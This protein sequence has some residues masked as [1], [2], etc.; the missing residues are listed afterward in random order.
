MSD[1]IHGTN[2]PF[3]YVLRGEQLETKTGYR[4]AQA[5]EQRDRDLEDF[6]SELARTPWTDVTLA[7]T[8]ANTGGAFQVTQY[9]KVGD[10]VQLRGHLEPGT[11]G[12]TAFALPI[13]FR[14]PANVDAA[15]SYGPS[16]P[17]G[18]AH[19]FIQSGGNVNIYAPAGT[20]AVSFTIQFSVTA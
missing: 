8:W 9:R 15:V 5:Y 3:E 14:P 19:L 7:G 18:E 11:L 10:M 2:L 17:N 13:G 12:A 4:L 1:S 16:P 20:T 6:L